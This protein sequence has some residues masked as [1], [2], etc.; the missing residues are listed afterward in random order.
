MTSLESDGIGAVKAINKLVVF[1]KKIPTE[2]NSQEIAI[3]GVT[4]EEYRCAFLKK[5]EILTSSVTETIMEAHPQ[6]DEVEEF[7]T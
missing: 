7:C 6:R 2:I 1:L 4:P 5:D 3:F